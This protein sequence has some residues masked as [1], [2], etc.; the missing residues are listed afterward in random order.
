MD[1]IHTTL[2]FIFV[3]GLLIFVHEYG[4]FWVARRCGVK[5][6]RFSIGFGPL[7]FSR[8]DKHGTEFALS[9]IPFGGYVKMLD[10]REGEVP[11]E[12][13]SQ[14][15]N[16]KSVGQRIAIV[17]GANQ[18][19]GLQLGRP[20]RHLAGRGAVRAHQRQPRALGRGSAC[21][22]PGQAVFACRADDQAASAGQGSMGSV[23]VQAI[24]S[25][26]WREDGGF[27]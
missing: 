24:Q 1:F 13:L 16:R 14:T 7:L 22:A 17:D 9:A 18:H 3:L 23:H 25:S 10:E 11:H 12:L 2:A 26:V 27:K 8:H 4:H 21:E 20:R 5:V 19:L 6:L 15:F